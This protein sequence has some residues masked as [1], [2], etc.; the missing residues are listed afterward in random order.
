MKTQLAIRKNNIDVAKFVKPFG[1]RSNNKP[2]GGGFWTSSQKENG[3]SDWIEF[4]E[5][6]EF[7]EDTEKLKVFS[8]EISD[9]ARVL[10]IDSKEDYEQAIE[11]YGV[12]RDEN[13]YIPSLMSN[14]LLNYDELMSDYDALSVTDKGRIDNDLAFYGWDCESTVWFNMDHFENI[15]EITNGIV[16][17][18]I[19]MLD[20]KE[21]REA[22]KSLALIIHDNGF[23]RSITPQTVSKLTQDGFNIGGAIGAKYKKGEGLT[24]WNKGQEAS[25]MKFKLSELVELEKQLAHEFNRI[26]LGWG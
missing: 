13:D 21:L 24:V 2:S 6:E 18:E 8:I 26:W 15:K 14:T 23:S 20:E 19:H 10:I 1:A 12:I 7:Y 5:A 11:K 16:Q 17:E 3:K 4:T 22:R 25:G 9:D